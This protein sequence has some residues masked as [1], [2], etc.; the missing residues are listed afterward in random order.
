MLV[1]KHIDISPPLP[2]PAQDIPQGKIS[3]GK[4]LERNLYEWHGLMI[5]W[6]KGL[7]GGGGAMLQHCD[8]ESKKSRHGLRQF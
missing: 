8:Y 6:R 2:P 7:G 5:L 1:L 4:I 3:T